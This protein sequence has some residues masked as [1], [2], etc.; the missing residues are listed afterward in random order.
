M[1]HRILLT[2][3]DLDGHGAYY[4]HARADDAGGIFR[5][6]R[7]TYLEVDTEVGQSITPTQRLVARAIAV[8]HRNVGVVSGAGAAAL[9]HLPLDN[10]RLTDAI[11]VTRE[12]SG[13]PSKGLEF[14][15]G[16]L[17]DNDVA[18][19]AGIRVTSVSRTLR[20]LAIALP[21]DEAYAAMNAARRHGHDLSPLRSYEGEAAKRIRWLLDHT[22]DRS[23]SMGESLLDY[24]LLMAGLPLPLRQPTVYDETGTF[25]ARPDWLWEIG[26]IHEFDG[27]AKWLNDD[28]TADIQRIRQAQRRTADL[29]AL[30]W[31]VTTSQWRDVTGKSNVTA[32]IQQSIDQASKLP[33]PR[34]TVQ[35]LALPAVEFPDWH[36]VFEVP[37]IFN[38]RGT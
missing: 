8:G 37:A 4:Q 33:A 3:R 38:R 12:S 29:E 13:R 27:T 2:R 24:R 34:G 9:W 20:D 7:G 14:R 31:L 26:A 30:G 15:R 19:N 28:G 32:R 22:H 36:D 18:E 25:V 16:V 1:A 17:E 21:V 35:L 11:T 10:R 5:I 23:D 6:H